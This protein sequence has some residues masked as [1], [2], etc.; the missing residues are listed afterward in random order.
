MA[1]R[2]TIYTFKLNTTSTF[3]GHISPI[4]IQSVRTLGTLNPRGTR[5]RWC[6]RYRPGPQGSEGRQGRQ[7][8][9]GRRQAAGGHRQAAGGHRQAGAGRQAEAGRQAQAGTVREETS[10]AL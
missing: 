10:A 6:W 5:G 1:N 2:M 3:S 7:A 9:G 4:W 8:A